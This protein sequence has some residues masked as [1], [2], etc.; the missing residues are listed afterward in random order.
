[1]QRWHSTTRRFA[2]AGA[3][4][5]A[6]AIAPGFVSA[7][8]E[9]TRALATLKA[10]TKEGKGNEDA[11]PAW[12]TLV[13]K[14][15]AALLPTLEAIDDTNATSANWLRTAVDAIA[16][17]EKSAGRKLPADKLEAFAK[18]PKFAPSARRLAYELLLSQD[19]TAKDRLLPE[20]LNDRSPEL[21]R[22]AISHQLD[23]LE[24]L[25]RPTIKADLEKL[26]THTRDKD[27]VELLAKKLEE[28]GG[29]ASIS[30]HF[31]FVTYAALIGPFDST[32]GKGFLTAYPPESAKD[33]SGKFR[34]KEN[35]EL[36]WIASNTADRYGA[37]DLNKLLGKHKDAVAYAMAVI[38]AE[39]ETPCEIRVTSITSVQIFLNGKKL[40]GRDEYHHGAPFDAHI[41]R[42]TLQKGENVIVLKVCQNNQTEEWAQGWF[43]QM[44]VCDHTGGPLPLT[45]KVVLN[46]KEQ[47]IKLGFIPETPDAKE[48]KK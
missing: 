15:G 8:E 20:F 37:F 13:S 31:G 48:E 24:K 35:A 12:K 36:K 19:P 3:L 32:E 11:A 14:G 6:I 27:Q 5:V 39:K 26:F 4:G 21:R 46:G 44:R 16:E 43:F 29:K 47:T 10:V 45:Q 28:N 42:G 7:D 33:T 18:N 23:I 9:T 2:L 25:A 22:D 1:M 41:G 30:E 34:G 17:N 38:V 40:F